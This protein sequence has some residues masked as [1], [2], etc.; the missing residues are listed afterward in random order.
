MAR[1]DLQRP[2]GVPGYPVVPALFLLA[3][4]GL[5]AN[6]LVTAITLGIIAAGLPVYY[7]WELTA[8]RQ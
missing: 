1:L 2:H 3:S 8:L 5:V 4:S 7:L 6:A